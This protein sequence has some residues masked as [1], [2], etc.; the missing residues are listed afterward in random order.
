V[1]DYA[2]NEVLSLSP[3]QA[4]L[5]IKELLHEVKAVNGTFVTLFHN[6]ILSDYGIWKGWKGV[7]GDVLDMVKHD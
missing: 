2:L 6:E 4:L 7:Y 3:K 5:K 1:N